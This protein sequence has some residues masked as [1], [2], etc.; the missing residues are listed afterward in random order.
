M[1]EMDSKKESLWG[2]I[3]KRKYIPKLQLITPSSIWRVTSEARLY[4]MSLGTTNT[5]SN[6]TA[7]EE[8]WNG[9]HMLFW[10]DAWQELPAWR[11]KENL[12]Q[13]KY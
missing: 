4:G 13:I 3:W 9:Q 2:K 1:V 12:Q 6:N 10:D 5:S 7:F 8:V 11:D